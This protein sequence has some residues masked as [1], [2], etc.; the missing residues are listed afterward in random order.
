MVHSP[1]AKHR[2]AGERAGAPSSS[3]APPH[4]PNPPLPRGHHRHPSRL[5]TP[6]RLST[7]A[8]G[9]IHALDPPFVSSA[10]DPA[11]C[12]RAPA[13]PVRRQRT[14]AAAAA[15]AVGREERGGQ[16]DLAP[17]NRCGR[18]ASV[19]RPDILVAV[20][21]LAVSAEDI[22]EAAKAAIS[23]L[24]SIDGRDNP[25]PAPVFY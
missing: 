14:P 3:P 10:R 7:E 22:K 13:P 1:S 25:G 4:S 6:T 8:R 19:S 21:L 12:G 15:A 2:A 16:R 5:P 24:D 17:D 11:E 18:H 9:C 23:V 20:G